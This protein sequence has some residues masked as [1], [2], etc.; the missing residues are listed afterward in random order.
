MSDR[1]A[2][3]LINVQQA[4]RNAA[5]DPDQPESHCGPTVDGADV[6]T[7]LLETSCASCHA[8]WL[9]RAAKAQMTFLR[10]VATEAAQRILPCG[11]IVVHRSA[12]WRGCTGT[13]D[14][15]LWRQLDRGLQR[16]PAE[17]HSGQANAHAGQRVTT[18]ARLCRNEVGGSRRTTGGHMER[19]ERCAAEPAVLDFG[20]ML[21]M[22]MCSID[23][24]H[25]PCL[26]R[27]S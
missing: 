12:R 11:R 10:G 4:A 22:V 2:G 17:V 7:G 20:S 13:T 21:R 15:Q 3:F 26:V 9:S 25:G 8:V 1:V 24:L 18:A 14:D 23:G 19:A 6:L 5:R 27:R 16:S